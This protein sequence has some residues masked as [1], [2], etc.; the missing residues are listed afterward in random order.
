[1]TPQI[2]FFLIT[3]FL[4]PLSFIIWLWRTI[5][6]SK[7]DW[8]MLVLLSGTYIVL[9][10]LAGSWSWISYYVRYI[11]LGFYISGV[12]IS[13]WKCR[14]K[15]L[16][17]KRKEG[18]W[19]AVIVFGLAT[20]L[21][22]VML[23]FT[24]TGHFFTEQ[25]IQLEFPLKNGT[26]YIV[27]GGNS[28]LINI[29]HHPQSPLKFSVD[30]TELYPLGNR[31][32]GIYPDEFEGYAIYAKSVFSP[33]DGLIVDISDGISNSPVSKP[34]TTHFKGNFIIVQHKGI[35]IYLA[36]LKKGSI[37]VAMGDTVQRGQLLGQVG[38]SGYSNEPH[39]HIHAEVD[40]KNAFM[41]SRPV[42]MLFKGNFLTKNDYIKN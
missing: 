12:F 40:D 15:P 1:M 17:I 18:E 2:F 35:N 32:K 29:H 6:K 39:L 22:S 31:A 30:I 37:K 3:T 28:P 27:Q 11:F 19:F 14:T 8:L 23:I 13:L 38:S 26:Y 7:F 25:S 34:D 16:F 10:F 5:F 24:L 36:H 4:I 9:M 41:G 20:F 33:C 42:V 21:F